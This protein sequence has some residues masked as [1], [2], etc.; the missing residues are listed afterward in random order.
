MALLDIIFVPLIFYIGHLIIGRVVTTYR[1]ENERPLLLRLFYFHILFSILFGLYITIFGGDA[2]GYWKFSNRVLTANE[3]W[4]DFHE[5][6]TQY[7]RFITYPFS[8]ILGLSFWVGNMLFSLFGFGGFILIYLSLKKY[9]NVNPTVFGY[10]L[11]PLVLFLPNMHFWSSG[12]GKDSVIFFALSLFIFS[13]TNPLRNLPGI[14]ISF[15]LAYFIRPHIAL[16][17]IVGFGFSLLLSTKGISFF[18]RGVF[19]ALSIYIFFVISPAVFE[20]IG[21][22]E[23]NIESFDD[24]S[25]RRSI[26]LN[27]A[28]VG[29]AID[30]KNLSTTMKIL[31]FFFRPLFFDGGNIFGL[32]VSIENLFYVIMALTLFRL[33]NLY[34]ILKMPMHLKAALFVL[35]STAFFMSSS[36]SNLGIIIRQKNMVMFMFVLIV[37]Y[38]LGKYQERQVV[39]IASQV[40]KNP[41]AKTKIA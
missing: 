27:R 20:F 6:G 2:V 34:E 7:V 3:S 14:I 41:H 26:N 21:L 23:E 9:L 38:L 29:S 24:I 36:L 40:R 16:L 28:S 15:Y 12:I 10:R 32:I 8:H 39:K 4:F 13:L 25:A 18:W 22:D 31:T 19:F 17:M 33:R 37:M 30:I 35:G 11:F 5:A 1:I